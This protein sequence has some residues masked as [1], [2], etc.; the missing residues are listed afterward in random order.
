M[1]TEQAASLIDCMHW[2]IYFGVLFTLIGLSIWSC[3]L[4]IWLQ[5]ERHHEAVLKG[6]DKL[7]KKE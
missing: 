5:N 2:L 4:A 3:L 6:M 1:T 7:E